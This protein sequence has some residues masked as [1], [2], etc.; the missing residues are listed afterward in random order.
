MVRSRNGNNTLCLLQHYFELDLHLL[1]HSY[2]VK[3]N[4]NV[5]PYRTLMSSSTRPIKNICIGMGKTTT[6]GKLAARLRIEGGQKVLVAACD[7]FRAGA[8]E[9]L[10]MWAD[11]AEVDCYSPNE[12][13]KTPAAVLYGSLDHALDGSY[14]TLIVDTSGRL[15][16]N[17]ALTAELAK[18]KRVIQKRLSI[19][20]DANDKPMLNMNV[21]HETLLVID[22]AQGRMA[23][24]SAKQWEKE[25][26]LTGLVLTKLDGSARGGSVVAV[27]RELGLPVKLI[28]VGEG[29]DDLRDFDPASFVDGLLG[30]G[31][32]GGTGKSGEGKALEGR[33]REL[34]KA[35]DE[36]AKTRSPE[37]EKVAVGA[38]V[39][40]GAGPA[41]EMTLQEMEAPPADAVAVSD[42][43]PPKAPKRK[44]N[45][46]KK[47]KKRKGK[48]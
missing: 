42:S 38:E 40:A 47:K 37:K 36:R 15:S 48:R 46:K 10:E 2:L 6:I 28:G 27:S 41:G 17:D 12:Q 14:D 19:E 32:A 45:N 22:A 1:T 3:F 9:Q 39:G 31:D 8:V 44:P 13:Q 11:R 7:T 23:L 4:H 34:R 21:P 33:L 29:I 25:I 18:M 30:I 24:D 43:S 35:R 20:N 16:N 26:G 5:C